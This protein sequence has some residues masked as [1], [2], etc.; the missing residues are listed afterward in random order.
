[1]IFFKSE[2]ES[3]ISAT[4]VSVSLYLSF[5]ES[6][7]HDRKNLFLIK[8]TLCSICITISF[9]QILQVDEQDFH[10]YEQ[11]SVVVTSS[12]RSSAHVV[13]EDIFMGCFDASGIGYCLHSFCNLSLIFSS[14]ASCSASFL[15]M[16][17]I[18]ARRKNLE[19]LIKGDC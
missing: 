18:G 3:V 9:D 8:A 4:I 15:R 11:D 17:T 7:K 1:M 5:Y 13:H 10:V 19:L 12:R 6:I 2:V 14:L 16:G